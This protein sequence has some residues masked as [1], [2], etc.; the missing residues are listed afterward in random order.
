VIRDSKTTFIKNTEL[1][2]GDLLKFGIGDIL[3]V[4][5]LMVHGSEVMVDESNITGESK[6]IY[7]SP[8]T[9][10]ENNNPFMISGSKIIDGEGIM[11]VCAVGENTQLGQ[12]KM[13]VQEESSPTPLQFKLE[14]LS[15]SI[16]KIALAASALTVSALLIHLMYNVAEGTVIL[17]KLKKLV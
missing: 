5:G 13:K 14:G 6:E 1:L 12:L 9:P 2:V 8:P 3:P 17:I 11:V 4:D 7:K 16:A 10:Y 15:N